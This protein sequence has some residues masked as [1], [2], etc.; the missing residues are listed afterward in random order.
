MLI[1]AKGKQDDLLKKNKFTKK[2]EMKKKKR[3]MSVIVW[4][5]FVEFRY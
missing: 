5:S 3:I 1:Q 4:L 2:V